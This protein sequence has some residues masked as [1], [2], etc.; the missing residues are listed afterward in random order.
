[1]C[2]DIRAYTMTRH[3]PHLHTISIRLRFVHT[4]YVASRCGCCVVIVI[5]TTFRN[6]P[7]CTATRISLKE[8]FVLFPHHSTVLVT[9]FELS[10]VMQHAALPVSRSYRKKYG[11]ARQ[12]R[13]AVWTVYPSPQPAKGPGERRKLCPAVSGAQLRPKWNFVK[14]ECQR[15]SDLVARIWLNSHNDVFSA[16][17]A[18]PWKYKHGMPTAKKM[19]QAVPTANETLYTEQ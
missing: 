3:W 9:L 15:R 4:G 13:R 12:K 2:R 16:V 10:F 1:M 17:P 8:P 5:A 11:H 14:S 7:H 18:R 19:G 6:M